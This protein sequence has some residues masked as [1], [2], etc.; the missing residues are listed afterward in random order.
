MKPDVLIVQEMQSQSGVT[1]F[2]NNV[3]NYYQA[4]LYS[5]VTFNDGPDTDNS[6]FYKSSKINFISANYLSNGVLTRRIAEYIIKPK[7]SHETLRIYSLHLKA[8]ASDTA[9]RRQESEY[10]RDYLNQ[11]QPNTNFLLAGDYNI[12]GSTEAAY[13][14]LIANTSDNDGR[15]KDPLTMNGTWNQSAYAPY[16]TQAPQSYN[17]GMDDRF[18]MLLPSYSVYNNYMIVSSYKAFGNDGQHYNA[19]INRL[20]NYAVPDSVANGLYY[21]ADHIP[22]VCNFTFPDTVASVYLS[23]NVGTGWNIVSLPLSPDNSAKTAIFPD[24]ASN[25]YYYNNPNG[26]FY[27]VLLRSKVG[28]WLKFDSVY[29]ISVRGKLRGTD[30]LNVTSGWNLIGASD[31][32]VAVTQLNIQPTGIIDTPFYEFN[33]MYQPADTIRRG[34]GYFVKVNANGKIIF[35]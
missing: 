34:K 24:A 26:Y 7:W 23:M 27:D 14:T 20:P 33:L 10:L 25:A 22:V 11:L 32:D 13:Q 30:T 16:H 1:N 4:G 29:T 8:S 9:R 5:T 2:L 12:Y 17:G 6:I 28:Y 3:M 18:D 15:V 35:P 21:A 19:S 31:H